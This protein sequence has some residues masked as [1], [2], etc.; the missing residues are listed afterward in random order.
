MSWKVERGRTETLNKIGRIHRGEGG[1]CNSPP[2]KK[3]PYQHPIY[4]LKNENNNIKQTSIGT[5][6]IKN[7][8]N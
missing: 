5:I 1:D 2:P 7:L 4:H 3:T 6:K 8:G